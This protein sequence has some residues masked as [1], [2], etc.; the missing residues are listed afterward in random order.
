MK[1]AN[2]NYIRTVWRENPPFLHSKSIEIGFPLYDKCPNGCEHIQEMCEIY[3]VNGKLVESLKNPISSNTVK[4]II[5]KYYIP[6]ADAYHI[7]I[8]AFRGDF[9]IPKH[10][11][12]IFDL[13]ELI[14][15]ENIGMFLA[16]ETYGSNDETLLPKLLDTKLVDELMVKIVVY[17]KLNEKTKSQMKNIFTAL[18]QG[19]EA[20]NTP[21]Y[22]D[23]DYP[24][25]ALKKIAISFLFTK[26]SSRE[27]FYSYLRSIYD[28][29][30]DFNNNEEV[31]IDLFDIYLRGDGTEEE[32]IIEWAYEELIRGFAAD[33]IYNVPIKKPNNGCIFYFS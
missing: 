6:N 25:N 3:D 11:F 26:N 4:S 28:A 8:I 16:A 23:S 7:N 21:K 13:I 17:D 30:K 33:R 15:K 27:V 18:S 5:L 32:G 22:N 29:F 9:S 24:D 1:Q 2:V 19:V 31:A 12:F 20:V 14:D 10:F